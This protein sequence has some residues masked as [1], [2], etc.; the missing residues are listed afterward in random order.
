MGPMS[1][2]D[3]AIMTAYLGWPG[4]VIGGAGA[5]LVIKR[6]RVL[7]AVGVA[8]LGFVGCIGLRLA[9]AL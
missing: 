4:L 2:F 8:L 3:L 5:A 6:R 7:W 9:M 1:M